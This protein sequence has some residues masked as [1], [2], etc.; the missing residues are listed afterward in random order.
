MKYLIKVFTAAVFICTSIANSNAMLDLNESASKKSNKHVMATGFVDYPPFGSVNE[1]RTFIS[2]FDGFLR[3]YAKEHNFEIAFH[4]K[5]ADQYNLSVQDIR[6]GKIDFIIGIYSES[7]L[8]NGI[9]IVYPAATHNPVHIVMLPDRISEIKDFNDL[10]KLKGA[11]HKN[12]H[13][14]DYVNKQIKEYNIEYVDNSYELFE[15][16]FTREIDY[17]FS[18]KYFCMIQAAK[19]GLG[20]Q[21]SYSK[22]PIWNIPMFFGIS[23]SFRYRKYMYETLGQELKKPENKEKINNYLIEMINNIEKENSGVVPPTFLLNK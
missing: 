5:S 2:M 11:I 1:Y 15:K 21:I 6:S 8:Y 4:L 16:L 20:K 3:D 7:N 19:L 12:E 23:K 10:K 9:E 14:S 17:I 13:F 18:S 22:K